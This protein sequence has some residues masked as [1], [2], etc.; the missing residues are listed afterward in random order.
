MFCVSEGNSRPSCSQSCVQEVGL[1][2][3]RLLWIAIRRQHKAKGEGDFP[4]SIFNSVLPENWQ[5]RVTMMATMEKSTSLLG[6]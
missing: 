6:K 4:H 3:E 1:G 2:R 5:I